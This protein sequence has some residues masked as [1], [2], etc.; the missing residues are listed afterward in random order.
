VLGKLTEMFAKHEG[1]RQYTSSTDMRLL[2]RT[3][4]SR[5]RMS[6][7]SARLHISC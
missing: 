3:R 6:N 7:G 2:A 4:A 1:S 5:A